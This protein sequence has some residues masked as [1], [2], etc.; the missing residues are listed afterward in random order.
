MVA[1]RV[2]F[3]FVVS[4]LAFGCASTPKPALQFPLA[5]TDRNAAATVRVSVAKHGHG[6]GTIISLR[7]GCYILASE[8][9]VRHV[10]LVESTTV[11]VTV[12]NAAGIDEERPAKVLHRDAARDLALVWTQECGRGI[13]AELANDD[14]AAAGTPVYRIGFP[15][16]KVRASARG[17]VRKNPFFVHMAPAEL[18]DFNDGILADMV[19]GG[20]SSGAGVYAAA[21]GRLVG[22]HKMSFGDDDGEQ[23]VIV[24]TKEIRRLIRE[25]GLE[26]E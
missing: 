12:Q 24:S 22:I 14:E 8:H 2:V 23:S 18:A 17:I 25:Y 15:G 21:T 20:G 9:V 13:K 19:G 6:S 1:V 10:G 5:G 26:L 11:S 4:V 16:D 3:A 7:N